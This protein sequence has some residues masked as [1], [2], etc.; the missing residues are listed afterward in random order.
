M[1]LEQ[2]EEIK[3]RILVLAVKSELALTTNEVSEKI[4]ISYPTA[5]NLLFELALEGHLVMI[6]K[7]WTQYFKPVA[8]L[9]Q[10]LDVIR[11]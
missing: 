8:K 5:S 1:D 7:G 4:N 10:G 9:K 6:N 3:K 2:R 11:R